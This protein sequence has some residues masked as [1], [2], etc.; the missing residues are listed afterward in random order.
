MARM[1][2]FPECFDDLEQ[3]SIGDLK[4]LGLLR[5]DRDGSQ[6]KIVSTGYRLETRMRISVNFNTRLVMLE[7][8]IGDLQSTQLIALESRPSNLGKGVVWYFVCPASKRLCRKL[9]L[10][11]DQF[12]SRFA[13]PGMMYGTQI[14]KKSFRGLRSTLELAEKRN[15]AI[16]S[17][18]K[19][20]AK[21]FYRGKP[22]KNFQRLLG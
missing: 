19:K 14:E 12:F 22:T 11:E 7:F 6:K 17:L 4:R 2:T 1:T 13:Y 16:E 20:Y 8:T 21:P 5:S 15:K 3:I 10:L 18:K 9:Y